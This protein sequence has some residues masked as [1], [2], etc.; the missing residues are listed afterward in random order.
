MPEKWPAAQSEALNLDWNLLAEQVFKKDEKSGKI[1]IGGKE[2]DPAM[3]D[4]L[5]EQAR[6]FASS[7]LCEIL[8]ATI[9]N[10]SSN[11][12]LIQSG[13]FNHVEVAKM[14]YHWNFVLQ[15]MILALVKK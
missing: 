2:I 11:M 7:Q 10:E 4:I 5:R 9:V 3:R 13:N 1:T 15:S 6:N 14:L 12:A 8:N